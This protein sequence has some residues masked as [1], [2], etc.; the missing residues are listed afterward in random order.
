MCCKTI[1]KAFRLILLDLKTG[2]R[3][4]WPAGTALA[5]LYSAYWAVMLFMDINAVPEDR[6]PVLYLAALFFSFCVPSA[7][8]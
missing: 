2:V 6:L 3:R 4:I 1:G 7:V 8:Y 5:A